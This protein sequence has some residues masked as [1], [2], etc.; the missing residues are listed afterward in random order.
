MSSSNT[1]VERSGGSSNVSRMGQRSGGDIFQ[2]IFGWDPFRG[3]MGQ[4]GFP[5]GMDVNRSEDGY[6]VEIPVPGFK[7]EE[8]EIT[9]QDDMLMVSGKGER[10][11]FTR[12]LVLPDE[13][14]AENV[15][16]HVENGLLCIHLSRRP[17]T[18]PRRI[19]VRS[20][21]GA[22]A[23]P[24]RISTVS[25]TDTGAATQ[26]EGSQTGGSTANR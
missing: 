6:T 25:G 21:A 7:P 5:M 12:S 24:E 23:A 17:E 9:L 8:I 1:P 14:D 16:A 22:H 15:N 4:S 3:M 13:I 18:R 10:R 20:G 19:E 11:Q 26:M 2:S